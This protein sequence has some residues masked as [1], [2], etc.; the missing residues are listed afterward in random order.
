MPCITTDLAGFG[1]WS[2][3]EKGKDSDIED[4]VQVLHRTDYNYSDVADGIKDTIIRYAAMPKASVDKC[5]S[6]AVKLSKKALWS[7]FIKN[8][9]QAYDIALHKA[10]SRTL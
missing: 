3:E 4:G 1:L 7:K 8:Y 10:A 9:E 5:R 2:N 6:H